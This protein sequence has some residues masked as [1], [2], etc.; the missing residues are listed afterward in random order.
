MGYDE[1]RA[2]DATDWGPIA[3]AALVVGLLGVLLT[4]IEFRS[5]GALAAGVRA[6]AGTVLLMIV[7][8]ALLTYV[9]GFRRTSFGR[10]SLLAVGLSF[11][12]FA[13]MTTIASV[14]LPVL[15]FETPFS[16]PALV[17][18][19]SASLLL[20]L[21]ALPYAGTEIYMPRLD[22]N[23]PIPVVSLIVSLPSLAALGAVL[24][25]PFETNVGVFVFV[26]AVLLVVVLAAT[27]YLP[28]NLYPITVFFV[29][30]STF[31]HRNLL[32]EHVIGA[33]VQ[34]IYATAQA[35][36]RADYWSP[37]LGGSSIATLVV[38]AIPAGF[39]TITGLELAVVYKVVYVLLFALVPVGIYY[40]SSD[41]LSENIALFGAFVF[42]FYH[43]SF[44]FTPSKQLISELFAVLL[45]SLLFR[46]DERG[47]GR[48]LAIGLLSVGLVQSH[49]GT[50]YVY[51]LSLLAAGIGLT[52]VQWLTEEFDHDL[53]VGYPVVLLTGATA[54]YAYASNE[55][56]ATLVS[57]PTSLLSQA[58]SLLVF[59]SIEGSGASY[60]AEQTGVFDQLN[61]FLYILVLALATTGLAYRVV[62]HLG[63]IYRNGDSEHIEY[64]ALAVPLFAFLGSSYFLIVNL[65]ADRV[66]QM[67]LVVLAPL[68]AVGY[69]YVAYGLGDVR[70]RLGLGNGS[71]LRWVP[72]AIL[73]AL[74]LA[75]NS[76]L[77]FS[78]TGAASTSAFNPNAHDLAFSEEERAGAAWLDEYTTIERIEA[79]RLSLTGSDRATSPER[80]R[81]YTDSMS[82]QMFRSE[83]PS[84]YYTT[85]VATLKSD[86]D[87][88]LDPD[89]IDRGYVFVRESSIL[90]GSGST[91]VSPIYLSEGETRALTGS[92]DV[93]YDNEAIRIV[94][95]DNETAAS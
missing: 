43:V 80:V 92:R 74:L 2:S 85:E 91:R 21:I 16:L 58:A 20:P 39:A 68:T 87:P 5:V 26:G 75:F 35:I 51:G 7:P 88:R 47:V 78:L 29:S 40:L 95:V 89:S 59:E 76:G 28:A 25:N 67:V 41:A 54:W 64:T 37:A 56:T 77:V 23:G 79:D 18:V 36:M 93:V 31:L 82:A 30:F 38:T 17:A 42:T 15:G 1:S 45:L 90:E 84:S 73:V 48:T 10:F 50:T 11:G 44:Y 14:L 65:Y 61:L 12:T 72:I 33:D 4:S 86:F 81:I 34:A 57:V 52:V 69:G 32:T 83:L 70:S 3:I 60:I 27:R 6:V 24:M 49:Y 66:I 53:S 62:V 63:E 55:L 8:G 46:N 19:L 22:L 94:E 71:R 9:L 13:T